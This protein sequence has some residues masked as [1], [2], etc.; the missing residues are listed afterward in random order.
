M[1]K[2]VIEKNRT[3]NEY[4]EFVEQ[5]I[6]RV[7]RV[8]DENVHSIYICGSIPKGIAELYKS[9]ADF[10]IVLNTQLSK[11]ER[12]EIVKIKSD[13]LNEYPFVTKIDTTVLT[14]LDVKNAPSDLGFWIKIICHC[15]YGMDLGDEVP[16]I[17]AN[18]ELILRLLSDFEV[19]INRIKHKLNC[20]EDKD[21]IGKTIRGYSKRLIRSLYTLLLEDIGEWHDDI[22]VMKNTLCSHMKENNQLIERLFHSYMNHQSDLETFE[23]IAEQACDIIHNKIQ[24]LSNIAISSDNRALPI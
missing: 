8:N 13:L 12:D 17:N 9:D 19:S 7:T 3:S 1:L 21:E 18:S 2:K 15:I 23:I 5:F 16:E 4:K 14:V 20:I 6:S 11:V 24:E 22:L 10:T